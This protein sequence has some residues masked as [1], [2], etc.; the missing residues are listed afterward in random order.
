MDFAAAT[1]DYERW[2]KRQLAAN[3]Q[4]IDAGDLRDKHR[5]MAR[6][7]R[8]YAFRFLRAT[9]YRWAQLWPEVCKNEAAAPRVLAVGDIHLENFGTWRDAEGRLCWGI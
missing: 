3:G 7:K 1:R 5:T 4:T 8:S 2:M 9:Y 6:S